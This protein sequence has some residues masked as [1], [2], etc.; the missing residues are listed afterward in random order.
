MEYRA[1]S[2][3]HPHL[4]VLSILVLFIFKTKSV[5]QKQVNQAEL[6]EMVT[7]STDED[8]CETVK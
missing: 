7:I 2:V 5:H 1:C 4:F 3:L 8:I 6:L